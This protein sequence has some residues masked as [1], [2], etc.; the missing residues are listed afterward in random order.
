MNTK[1]K[2]IAH[3]EVV[4]VEVY[5][6]VLN[7]VVSLSWAFRDLADVR[8]ERTRYVQVTILPKDVLK[9]HAGIVIASGAVLF[10]DEA[11]V[12]DAADGD[13]LDAFVVLLRREVGV[14]VII[15]FWSDWVQELGQLSDL[16]KAGWA[17]L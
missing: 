13:S 4:Y 11:T 15:I 5:R 12:S 8:Y 9:A 1:S 7:T 3:S 14:V 17:I 6:V 2:A 16:T 10:A